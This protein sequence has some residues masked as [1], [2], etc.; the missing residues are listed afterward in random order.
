MSASLVIRW[1]AATGN[2]HAT[3]TDQPNKGNKGDEI[4]LAGIFRN[5]RQRREKRQGKNDGGKLF[6]GLLLAA[7]DQPENAGADDQN[8]APCNLRATD[9][10]QSL[11]EVRAEVLDGKEH[12]SPERRRDE[13]PLHDFLPLAFCLAAVSR[14]ATCQP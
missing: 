13:Q 10:D 4:F 11:S 14:W 1:V 2:N 6:H 7:D 5:R 8:P 12:T 3:A 9:G